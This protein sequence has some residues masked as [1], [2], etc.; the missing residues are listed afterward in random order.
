MSSEITLVHERL[1]KILKDCK[2]PTLPFSEFSKPVVAGNGGTGIIYKSR[3]K[4]QD[5]ALKSITDIFSEN[6]PDANNQFQY[7]LK[8]LSRITDHKNVIKQF[9]YTQDEKSEESYIV[10]E[11]A[12][13]GTLRDYLKRNPHI[14]C[15]RKVE[16]A[17]QILNGLKA[18]H[19]NQIAH[20]DLHTKNIL[21]MSDGAFKIADLGLSKR[22]NSLQ[23]SITGGMVAFLEPEF[24]KD[25]RYKRDFASDIYAFGVLLWEISACKAPFS[26]DTSPYY[27]AYELQQGRRESP[28]IG[29]PLAYVELYQ[30][31]WDGNPQKRPKLDEVI[32]TMENLS[33][34][35]VYDG[36]PIDTIGNSEYLLTYPEDDEISICE[37]PDNNLPAITISPAVD[38][39]T[40]EERHPKK[41][42]EFRS[43]GKCNLFFHIKNCDM[44]GAF[45]HLENGDNPNDISDEGLTG[46]QYT[47]L[48]AS[49]ATITGLCRKLKDY[50]GDVMAKT[51]SG[52]NLFHLL[53]HNKNN[54]QLEQYKKIGNWLH[55]NKVEINHQDQNGDTALNLLIEAG[56]SETT[57]AI[58]NVLLVLGADS[59][60]RDASGMTAFQRV[61]HSIYE[62]PLLSQKVESEILEA[63][64]K[65]KANPNIIFPKQ[66]KLWPSCPS[67]LF[68][69]IDF[70][71]GRHIINSLKSF[72]ADFGKTYKGHSLLDYATTKKKRGIMQILLNHVENFQKLEALSQ[73]LQ[74]AADDAE[75]I[76]LTKELE[77]Y[78]L[79]QMF[80][81]TIFPKNSSPDELNLR[82]QDLLSS[83][84]TTFIGSE[85][86]QNGDLCRSSSSI[87][88]SEGK[89]QGKKDKPKTDRWKRIKKKFNFKKSKDIIVTTS[90]YIDKNYCA[91]YKTFC[92]IPNESL[93]IST[94]RYNVKKLEKLSTKVVM[95]V[96][97][98]LQDIYGEEKTKRFRKKLLRVTVLY[99]GKNQLILFWGIMDVNFYIRILRQHVG[100]VNG[101]IGKKW[102]FQQ[103]N[104]PKHTSRVAKAFLAGNLSEVID[105]PVP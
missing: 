91:A 98:K 42:D 62:N 43:G 29:T 81:E 99:E 71:D 90:K 105:W 20:R 94:V 49:N 1:I 86:S 8:L 7:E 73:A 63:M 93:P 27:L 103:D 4:D 67:A 40:S 23:V 24:Y 45:W 25:Q 53:V 2:I 35:P 59:N 46:I 10:L 15:N 70:P 50:N 47:I 57:L 76:L 18:I 87:R 30:R 80:E 51:K 68:A 41:C 26:S 32:Q 84:T 52:E 72:N 97:R 60:I 33:F 14:D 78:P 16:I 64:L 12:E 101:I 89:A 39:S 38:K 36:L 58:I 31:C 6:N 75:H 95:V 13:G 5:V 21:I 69:A 88:T 85:P 28:K 79:P 96:I 44:S 3:W 56:L 104:N 100:D 65:N 77:K 11:W 82:P 22:E 92:P 34:S 48:F 55:K 19:N 74:Y 66:H 17:L 61:L 102:H 83:Q 54:I 37:D 9:G